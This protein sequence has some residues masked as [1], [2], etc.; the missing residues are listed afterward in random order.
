[1]TWAQPAGGHHAGPAP[2]R[3]RAAGSA[4]GRFRG[5]LLARPH[6]GGPQADPCQGADGAV[7]G[8]A[9]AHDI[10]QTQPCA[11]GGDGA[12]EHATTPPIL[13]GPTSPLDG[14]AGVDLGPCGRVGEQVREARARDRGAR[15]CNYLGGYGASCGRLFNCVALSARYRVRMHWWAC[16]VVACCLSVAQCS[17]GVTDVC[18]PCVCVCV[19]GL[20]S[21]DARVACGAG[22]RCWRDGGDVSQT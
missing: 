8:R 5:G 6:H 13:L 3:A 1:M 17:V 16:C 22:D 14:G 21:E 19:W 20:Q 11:L 10:A 2:R 18:V 4:A 15:D 7:G 9:Q 12:S